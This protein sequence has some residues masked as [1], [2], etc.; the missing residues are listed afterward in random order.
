MRVRQFVDF[1]LMVAAAMF[2][3]G[4]WAHW[5]NLNNQALDTYAQ[6]LDTMGT[7]FPDQPVAYLRDLCDNTVGNPHITKEK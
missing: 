4:G 5:F 7:K 1:C 3:A 2:L 6:C